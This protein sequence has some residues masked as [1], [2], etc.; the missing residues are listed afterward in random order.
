[1]SFCLWGRAK[2]QGMDYVLN[3]LITKQIWSHVIW[4]MLFL[5]ASNQGKKSEKCLTFSVKHYLKPWLS[6]CHRCYQP[7]LLQNS[8]TGAAITTLTHLQGLRCRA[9]K[10]MRLAVQKREH[11]K[12][13]KT[14]Q[15]YLHLSPRKTAFSSPALF[16]SH[17][18]LCNHWYESCLK[19]SG[20]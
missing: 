17:F 11:R 5:Q 3:L 18:T 7:N 8:F 19:F 16:I 20:F 9:A 14:L 15:L 2:S 12:D 4:K 1:M 6:Q 10:Y 13:C